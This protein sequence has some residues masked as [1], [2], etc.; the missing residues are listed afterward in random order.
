MKKISCLLI[1]TFVLSTTARAQTTIGDTIDVCK[2]GL[3]VPITGEYEVVITFSGIAMF[4]RRDNDGV[5]YVRLPNAQQGRPKIPDPQQ[6]GEVLRNSIASHTAYILA[7]VRTAK[8]L[9]DNDVPLHPAY[10]EGGCY[11]Y[12]PLNGHVVTL[13]DA[14]APPANNG[15]LC[16]TDAYENGKYCPNDNIQ[17]G[18]VTK[19]SMYWLPSIKSTLGGAQTPEPGHFLDVP[20]PSVLSGLIKVDRGYLETVVTS[21][22]VWGFVMKLNEMGTSKLQTIAQE[23]RWHLRGKGSEFKLQLK[24]KN[25]NPI[26]LSFVPVNGKVSIFIGNNPASD[27]GPVRSAGHLSPDNHFPLY[28]EFVKDFKPETGPLPA[29]ADPNIYKCPALVPE[30]PT[31]VRCKCS[32]PADPHCKPNEEHPVPSGLNCGGTQWP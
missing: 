7:D 21:E 12:Y 22:D 3:G 16:V 6:Q 29:H 10:F 24:K 1:L 25:G 9:I 13:V 19:G 26:E 23:V 31:L 17:N 27:T 2:T 20:D 28:Y 32:C 4:E 18:K 15:K 14:T 11:K 8:P 30:E 5:I